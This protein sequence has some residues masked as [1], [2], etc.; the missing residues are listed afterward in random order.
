MRNEEYGSDLEGIVRLSVKE[1]GREANTL[2]RVGMLI[3]FLVS[4]ALM[5]CARTGPNRI[6]DS[7]TRSQIVSGSGSGPGLSTGFGVAALCL[8]SSIAI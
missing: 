5:G 2:R 4:L 6:S 7:G 1:D 8:L 3:V